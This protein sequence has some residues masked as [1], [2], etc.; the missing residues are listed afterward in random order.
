MPKNAH[1][2]TRAAERLRGMAMANAA[3]A[4]KA[5]AFP[6]HAVD[7]AVVPRA[8]F[9][10]HVRVASLEDEQGRL[11]G[12]VDP[13]TPTSTPVTVSRRHS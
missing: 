13:N 2:T 1:Y 3:A 12:T 11:D 4:A 7:G 10:E 8:Q 5:L 6:D 9:V